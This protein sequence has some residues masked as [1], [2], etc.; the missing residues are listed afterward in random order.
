MFVVI[1]ILG[2]FSLRLFNFLGLENSLDWMKFDWR[3]FM[4]FIFLMDFN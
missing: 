4:K 2:I 1:V 3:G